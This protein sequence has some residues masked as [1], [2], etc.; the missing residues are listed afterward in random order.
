MSQ[1][2][3]NDEYNEESK[4]RIMVENTALMLSRRKMYSHLSFEDIRSQFLE[5]ING[6]STSYTNNKETIEVYLTFCKLTKIDKSDED[7]Y[8][9]NDPSK[10]KILIVDMASPKVINMFDVASNSELVFIREMMADRADHVSNPTLILLSDEEQEQVIKEY[11]IEPG[12]LPEFKFGTDAIAR[13]YQLK[14][15]EIC[16][17]NSPSEAGYSIRYRLCR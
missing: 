1:D 3:M 12:H 6:Y 13:Y 17:M 7:K 5:N 14:R 10:Y 11:N 16:E 2:Y 15:G 4:I 9:T 8:F